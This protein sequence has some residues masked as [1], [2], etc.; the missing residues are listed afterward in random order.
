MNVVKKRKLIFVI[1]IKLSPFQAA[2]G[3]LTSL[4]FGWYRR[5]FSSGPKPDYS[6]PPSV[7]V[8]NNWNGTST[9]SHS[10]FFVKT[11]KFTF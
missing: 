9:P 11:E 2:S 4:L 3:G 8:K 6:F 1:R 7:K 5:V 10:Y